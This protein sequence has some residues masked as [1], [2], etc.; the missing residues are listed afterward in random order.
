MGRFPDLVLGH[1][2]RDHADEVPRLLLL[3]E[4]VGDVG[5]I[6][7]VALVVR[8]RAVDDRELHVRELCRDLPRRVLHEEPDGDDQV[9]VLLRE[10]R[11]VRNVVFLLL[12]LDD[13]RL[14]AEVLLG[15]ETAG[16]R[17]LVE[18]LVVQT[19]DVRD[20][21]DLDRLRRGRGRT[22]AGATAPATARGD[23]RGREQTQRED[24]LHEQLLL[25][26]AAAGTPRFE[27]RRF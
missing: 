19:A 25:T 11:Q 24:T 2:R 22:A 18:A 15:L 8:G 16:V 26:C 6:R 5:E 12:R 21:P 4:Q 27:R 17:G 14:E 9:V 20:E 7:G 1:R 23:D 3:E 13:L 10:R